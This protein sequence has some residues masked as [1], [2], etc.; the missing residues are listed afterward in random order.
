[1]SLLRTGKRPCG[2]KLNS[3]ASARIY[4]APRSPGVLNGGRVEVHEINAFVCDL[5]S[6]NPQIV[7]EEE[8]VFPVGH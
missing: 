3:T 7:T 6:R 8:L 1:M 4:A 2:A 5:L